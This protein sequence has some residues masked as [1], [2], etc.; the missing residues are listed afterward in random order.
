MPWTLALDILVALLLAATI[1]ATFSLNRR[2]G[3][4]RSD[5]AE[6]EKLAQDFLHAMQRADDGVAGLKVST[7][8]MQEHIEAARTLADD[9]EY[10]IDRGAGVADR[11]ESTVRAIRRSD[12]GGPDFRTQPELHDRPVAGLAAGPAAPK[13]AAAAKPVAPAKPA[14]PAVAP[15]RP[16]AGGYAS[17]PAAGAAAPVG[18]PQRQPV[19]AAVAAAGEPRS[20]AE[21][22][23][24]AALRA[25]G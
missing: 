10:L 22:V 21:R 20:E 19:Q 17:R 23:L 24:L 4:L 15:A 13:P 1:A 12:G 16:A 25:H 8:S 2:L 7:H 14:A 5:R 18:K 9:L 6:L 11:L 3:A